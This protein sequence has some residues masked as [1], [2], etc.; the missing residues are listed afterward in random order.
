MTTCFKPAKKSP[1]KSLLTHPSY[2]NLIDEAMGKIDRMSGFRSINKKELA[3][4]FIAERMRRD[5]TSAL[6]KQPAQKKAPQEKKTIANLYIVLEDERFAVQLAS[7]DPLLI[8]TETGVESVDGKLPLTKAA[9]C[10]IM[11]V[12]NL[13][14]TATVV[15]ITIFL[16]PIRCHIGRIH[17]MRVWKVEDEVKYETNF[18]GQKE[19]TIVFGGVNFT[20]YKNKQQ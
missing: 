14:L 8:K 5:L 12:A 10:D 20:S 1:W 3:A 9:I 11:L 4:L 17:N 6:Q 2:V 7:G 15:N 18:S 19:D 16:K 13:A